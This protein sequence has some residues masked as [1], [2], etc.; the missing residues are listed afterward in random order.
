M[1]RRRRRR[2]GLG[3]RRRVGRRRRRARYLPDAVRRLGN[4]TG[5]SFR[6][7]SCDR[8]S[9]VPEPRAVAVAHRLLAARRRRRRRRLA[10]DLAERRRLLAHRPTQRLRRVFVVPPPPPTPTASV[11]YVA[12]E[13]AARLEHGK[14]GDA[15]GGPGAALRSGRDCRRLVAEAVVMT[16]TRRGVRIASWTVR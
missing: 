1:Q 15:E 8:T 13:E 6:L 11:R 2:L 5:A 9:R 10:L 4:G 12:E 3:R 14:V 7:A 16:R